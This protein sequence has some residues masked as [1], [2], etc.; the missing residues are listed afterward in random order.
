[1]TFDSNCPSCHAPTPTK[2]VM[3]DIP[4]FKE[5]IIMAM[6]CDYCG[7]KSN[8]VKAGGAIPQKGKKITFK[9]I[10]AEDLAR[11]VLKSETATVK[12]P[13]LQIQV[14]A[15]SLGGRFT[16]VEGLLVGIKDDIHGNQFFYGDSGVDSAKERVKQFIERM[17]ALITGKELPWTLII[18]DPVANSYLQNYYAPDPDPN[19]NVEEY[20]R[21]FEENEELGLNDIKTENYE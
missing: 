16:T 2:M 9:V 12:I 6:S 17:E 19:M 11:N 5:V 3:V 13:E 20:D 10:T 1:M 18:E 8:E 14:G 21:S 7:Y 15:G 4:Y